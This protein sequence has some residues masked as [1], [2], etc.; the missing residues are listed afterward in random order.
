MI[1]IFHIDLPIVLVVLA[2]LDSLMLYAAIDVAVELS[3]LGPSEFFTDLPNVTLQKAMFVVAMVTAL[4]SMGIYSEEALAQHRELVARAGAA[5]LLAFIMLVVVFY[6]FP[7]SRIWMSAM[8]PAMV[9]APLCLWAD[10]AIFGRAVRAA[11]FKARILVLGAG[12]KAHRV[13]V[14]ERATPDR[15][16]CT[17]FLAL[18][19]VCSVD[20][21][22]VI[23]EADVRRIC[24]ILRPNEI[25][26]ALAERRNTMPTDA[27]IA[28]RLRGIRVVSLQSFLERET[29][30]IEVEHLDPSWLVFSDG[31]ARGAAGRAVKRAFDLGMSIAFLL[32]TLPVL[33]VVAAAIWIE[34]GRPIFYT[35]ERV[36][37]YGRIFRIIKFRSMRVDAERDGV[38]RW[39][40]RKDPRVTRV[41]AFLRRSRIDEVPQMINVLKGDMS[42]VGPRPERPSM[43]A[44]ITRELPYYE[45]RHLVK[46][47]IT[48]WAQIRHTYTDSLAGALE[49]L[50]YD[51]YYVKNGGI[52]FD[53]VIV[54]QT[55]RVVLWGH[56][57]R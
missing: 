8:L 33:L 40:S 27:L 50:K 14:L 20:P 26:V 5:V 38:A 6:L 53:A 25:V 32:A 42:L 15:F 37:L 23:N 11:M 52:F 34:D 48:G 22:R 44:K 18:G 24:N 47:G 36:G 43:V 56:G 57:A 49:K 9:A 16:V 28:C 4:F 55:V 35:Q 17:G 41:G 3:R 46:P 45:Y 13:E 30:R 29:G 31:T 21:R 39:A 2:A 7:S 1:R 54:L 12:E 19:E 10:R 51:L